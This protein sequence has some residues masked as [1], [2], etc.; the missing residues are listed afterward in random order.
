MA[1]L[2]AQNSGSNWTGT[3]AYVL[4]II[5]L[6]VGI[7]IGYLVR[8]SESPTVA[9]P[10][11]QAQ[12]PSGAPPTPGMGGTQQPTPE[13]MKHMADKTAEPLLAQLKDKPNDAELLYKVGNVYYDAQQ[14]ADAVDYYKKS[15]KQNPKSTDV[16][17]DMATAIYYMGDADASLKEFDVV[18]KDNPNHANALFNQGMIRWRGKMDIKGA[19][20]SWKKLL[21][22]N[23]DFP[24]RQEVEQ[25]MAEADKHANM[26]LTG[27]QTAKQ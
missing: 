16:R 17:T 13:Q 12:M 8:G 4:A 23:P 14:Y 22:A 9:S 5:C 2:Q 6:V 7:A 1:D 18:L 11:V 24:R 3:Q 26:K 27:K 21:A 25:L 15:L 19:A 10:A 20:E